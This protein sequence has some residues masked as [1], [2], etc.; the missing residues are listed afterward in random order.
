MERLLPATAGIAKTPDGT[1]FDCSGTNID[2]GPLSS[3]SNL[4]HIDSTMA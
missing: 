4:S 1:G 3:M 2:G